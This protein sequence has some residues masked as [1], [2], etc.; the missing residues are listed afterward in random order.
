M[1]QTGV[2]MNVSR[3][4]NQTLLVLFFVT[5]VSQLTA[6]QLLPPKAA[7]RPFRMENHGVVRVDDY[8]WMRERENPEVIS[9]L[10]AENAYS[11]A[12][13]EPTQA[14]Q[15][16]LADELKTRIPQ[17][18]ESVHY[19]E[20]GSEWFSRISEGQQYRVFFRKPIGTDGAEEIVVDAN[21]VAGESKF[22]SLSGVEPSPDGKTVAWAV[23]L[24]GRRKYTLKFRDMTTGEMLPDQCTDV[25]GAVWAEDN[26]TLFYTRQD[27][28]TLRSNQVFRHRLGTDPANDELV[29]DETDEEF[30]VS[31][32]KTRSNQ[33]IVIESSQTLS[34]ECRVI[35]AHHPELEPEVFLAREPDHEYS[36]DHIGDSFYV[37]T[38][39]DARNFRLMKS[40]HVGLDKTEWKVVVPHSETQFLESFALFNNWLVIEQ[41]ENGLTE[42]RYRKWEQAEFSKLVFDEPCYSAGLAV[43]DLTDTNQLRFAY[44]SLRTPDSVFDFDMATGDKTLLKQTRIGG[45]FDRENYVAERQWATAT[46]G[47]KVPVS[48]VYRKNTRLDG[49]APCLLYGYG[50]YGSSTSA[51]FDPAIL[52]LLDRGWVYAIAH[53]RGGQ[54]MGRAWYEDGK[55]LKKKNTFTDFID[56]GKFLVSKKYCSPETLYANGGSAGGL[57]IGAVA[58]MAPEL[59]HGLIAEVAFVDVIT[60]MLDETIPLTTGEYD[61]WGNPNEEAYF[62]YMLSYSPYDNVQ[63]KSYPHLLVT[64]GLHDSQVQYWEPA[65]WV[66]KLREKKT[67]DN[68]L[69]MHTEMEAGHGGASGRMD[70]YRE[71]A[72]RQAFLIWLAQQQAQKPN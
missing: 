3:R 10:T 22:C 63:A 71:T 61:E 1:Q 5:A 53:I 57:L 58:N 30:S 33:Y 9:W 67:G 50:S 54:E 68:V 7:K 6:Q 21:Q 55:L 24:V 72:L 46:D 17:N 15:E 23:D 52:N 29:F 39:W 56:C 12:M 70:Q 60:T 43:T 36:I 14:L 42:I 35:N 44:S 45:G 19:P 47:T 13:L 26:Q 32:G 38:N 25:T 64:T 34:S 16:L 51:E 4:F 31:V 27:P 20:S 37:R 18:D 48:I 40:A 66:A 2:F 62:H 41:L 11:E 28:D 59:F 8:Y 69:L 49:T 65:K